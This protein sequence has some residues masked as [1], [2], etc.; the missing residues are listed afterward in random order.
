MWMVRI[1]VLLSS[2]KKGTTARGQATNETLLFSEK[3]RNDLEVDSKPFGM[4]GML[5]CRDSTTAPVPSLVL[6]LG[7]FLLPVSTHRLF[8]PV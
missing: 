2:H 1:V 7:F 3:F 4:F 6:F 5:K 8:V